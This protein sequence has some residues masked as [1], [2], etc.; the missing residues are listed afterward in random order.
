MREN[1][2]SAWEQTDGGDVVRRDCDRHPIA[3]VCEVDGWYA[4]Q[5]F[6]PDP[7]R[8]GM[9]GRSESMSGAMCDSNHAAA[10]M[11]WKLP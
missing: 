11:G 4:W 3:T 1:R 9:F 8:D 7:E 10:G 6:A 5:V 2:L